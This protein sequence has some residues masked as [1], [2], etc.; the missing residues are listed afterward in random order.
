VATTHNA[1]TGDLFHGTARYEPV[2]FHNGVEMASVDPKAEYPFHLSTYKQPIHT[3][4][5]TFAYAWLRE[6]MPEAFLDINPVDAARLHVA[7]GDRVRVSSATYPQGIVTKVRL[8]PAVRPGVV[9]FPNS[10]GHWQY[11]SGKW[12]INGVTYAGDSSRNA[13]VRLNAL[14][15]LDPSLT[16]A[17]GWGT[18]LIDQVGG[19]CNYYDTRVK[20]E[21]V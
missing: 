19:G 20:I 9:T 2:A 6:L 18:C 4:A 13:P 7:D 1:I 12:T 10:F 11:G 14:M 3:H 5:R 17:S 16:D 8:M 15:R 21:K